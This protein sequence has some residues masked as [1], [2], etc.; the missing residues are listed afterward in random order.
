M[1]HEDGCKKSEPQDEFCGGVGVRSALL[2]Q[3]SF[4]ES[5]QSFAYARRMP[6]IKRAG[7]R[8]TLLA[9]SNE[10]AAAPHEWR[11]IVVGAKA[12]YW[13]SIGPEIAPI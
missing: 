9:N 5:G 11:P 2:M 4:R 7:R 1:V 8:E 3:L 12:E 13:R 6:K 10:P